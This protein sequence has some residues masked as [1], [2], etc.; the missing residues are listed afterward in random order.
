MPM[1]RNVELVET[2]DCLLIKLT[3]AGRQE[4]ESQKTEET[5]DEIGWKRG[6]SHIFQDLLEWQLCN[7]WEFVNPEDIGALTSAPIL[8]SPNGKLYWF[9]D[10]AVTCEIEELLEKNEVRFSVA[11]AEYG[12]LVLIKENGV[13]KGFEYRSALR[14]KRK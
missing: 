14:V 3:E 12:K 5:D 10:Y 4:L 6:T 9:P 13:V 7:G 8:R 11:S 1:E 2:P